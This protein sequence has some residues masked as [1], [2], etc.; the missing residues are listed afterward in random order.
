MPEM[1]LL[2]LATAPPL[3]ALPIIMC[4]IREKMNCIIPSMSLRNTVFTWLVL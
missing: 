4:E 1:L 2:A 3:L